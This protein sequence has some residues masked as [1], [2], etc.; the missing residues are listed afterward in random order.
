VLRRNVFNLLRYDPQF[1][2]GEDIPFFIHML[3]LFECELFSQPIAEIY[4]H[5]D[6]MRH[7]V[8]Y[9]EGFAEN[10]AIATFD[11][12]FF[13]TEL[14]PYRKYFLVR[15]HLSMFRNYY[16]AQQFKAARSSYAKALKT[17]IKATLSPKLLFRWRRCFVPST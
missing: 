13:P 9:P 11:Q 8:N 5:A 12:P 16:R 4:K 10:L 7:Q 2:Q 14:K 3:V 1:R 17:S 6:S 15:R